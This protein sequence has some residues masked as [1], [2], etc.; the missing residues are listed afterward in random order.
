MLLF[1]LSLST[2]IDLGV[3][4]HI[5]GWAKSLGLLVAARVVLDTIVIKGIGKIRPTYL[6]SIDF[7][8]NQMR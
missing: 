3:L 6:L 4:M 1:V 8:V 7:Y 5:G 2:Q